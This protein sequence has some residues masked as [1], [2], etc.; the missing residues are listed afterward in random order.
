MG[1]VVRNFIEFFAFARHV[2]PEPDP[3]PPIPDPWQSL[4]LGLPFMVFAYDTVTG[5]KRIGIKTIREVTTGQ[6]LL[7]D[8]GGKYFAAD[9]SDDSDMHESD[10]EFEFKPKTKKRKL[11][12]GA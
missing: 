5:E 12:K 1:R 10:E 4:M 6:E 11:L 2:I 8:Y 7:V 3:T 9:S